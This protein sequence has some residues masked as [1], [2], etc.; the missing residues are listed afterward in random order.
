MKHAINKKVWILIV[1]VSILVG[2]GAGA[3]VGFMTG[4]QGSAGAKATH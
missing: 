1:F 4:H 3:G 2:A